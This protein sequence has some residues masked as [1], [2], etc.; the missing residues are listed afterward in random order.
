MKSRAKERW[1]TVLWGALT[2]FLFAGVLESLPKLLLF[3]PNTAL[4][5]KV[6]GSTV[7]FVVCGALLAAIFEETGRLIIFKTV[8]R[9]RTHRETGL[10]H[11]IGH[12]GCEAALILVSLAAAAVPLVGWLPAIGERC[13]AVLL[14]IALSITVFYGVKHH[15]IGFYFLAMLWHFLFDVPAALYQAGKLAL[16]PTEVVF[17]TFS[18]LVFG[19]AFFFLYKKDEENSEE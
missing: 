12:G 8:L 6:L 4:G 17:A 2:W 15:K 9:E 13:F 14:H 16:A 19:W 11:G 5:Q 10:F 18:V 7:L 1:T 3:N